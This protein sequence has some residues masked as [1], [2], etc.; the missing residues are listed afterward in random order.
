VQEIVAGYSAT[1]DALSRAEAPSAASPVRELLSG[2][3]TRG[4][5]ARAV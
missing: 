3:F 2:K 1:L 4:H 5:F